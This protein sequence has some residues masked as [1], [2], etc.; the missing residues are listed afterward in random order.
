MKRLIF[1][2]CLIVSV[3]AFAL[4]PLRGLILGAVATNYKYDPFEGIRQRKSK[5]LDATKLNQ[6]QNHLAKIE[7]ARML[8]A[9][10]EGREE[11]RYSTWED[12][13]NAIRSVVS[14]LQYIGLD[15][16]V[17]AIGA[18]AKKLNM[19]R[20]K[21]D[22]LVN[23][24]IVGKCTKNLTVYSL[25]TLEDNLY[26]SY[27]R[28][29]DDDLPKIDDLYED[30][31]LKSYME[32]YEAYNRSLNYTL[33]AFTSLCSWHGST[34][35][36]RLLTPYLKHPLIMSEVFALMEGVSYQVENQ[37][38]I[39]KEVETKIKVA[40]ENMICRPVPKEQFEKIYPRQLGSKSLRQDLEYLYCH[41][42]NGLDEKK[43][44]KSLKIQKLKEK[45]NEL[46]QMLETEQLVG[47]LTNQKNLWN[48]IDKVSDYSL[49][50]K[51]NLQ[52]SWNFWAETKLTKHIDDVTYEEPLSL[53]LLPS[54]FANAIKGNFAI[55]LS[56]TV[57]EYDNVLLK[58]D[59]IKVE[60]DLM[61]TSKYMKWLQK[62]YRYNL[63]KS[64]YRQLEELE[65]KLALTIDEK[66]KARKKYFLHDLWNERLS[67]MMA[68][69]L[70][71]QVN[72]YRGNQFRYTSTKKIPV[73]VNLRFGLFALQYLQNKY[74]ASSGV[75][76][77]TSTNP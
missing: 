62:E 43:V 73:K 70:L 7:A 32:S 10:C 71:R 35:D 12:Q 30:V 9:R 42:F 68:K 22:R 6:I 44:S 26:A 77:L 53:K 18:Y 54:N 21:F 56:L 5:Q 15:Y 17:K 50:L 25:K 29:T 55:D 40:C 16:T 37:K 24:L 49:I 69:D 39:K 47:L 27:K 36:Y 46:K 59:K 74:N 38:I 1:M 63:K 67:S 14:T 2:A 57:G 20:S 41:Y 64:K 45:K 11:L 13:Q 48:S 33:D 19:E 60:M 8:K 28:A 61:F 76:S 65:K 75:K 34:L 23:N 58:N 51:D 66:L 4:M 3:G 52:N 72:Y 31:S